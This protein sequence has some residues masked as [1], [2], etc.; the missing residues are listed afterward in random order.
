M[1][2]VILSA[3]VLFGASQVASAELIEIKTSCG[4]VVYVD[5]KDYKKATE[6]L[7]DVVSIEEA[8]CPR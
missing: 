4:K 7:D 8:L 3:L 2:K 1:K 5:S 6:L